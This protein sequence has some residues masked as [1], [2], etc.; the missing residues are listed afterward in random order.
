MVRTC[1]ILSEMIKYRDHDCD[2]IKL[3]YL[4]CLRDN[5]SSKKCKIKLNE[6]LVCISQNRPPS[7]IK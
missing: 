7:I 1:Y 6:L 2:K 5:N 4:N 3:D